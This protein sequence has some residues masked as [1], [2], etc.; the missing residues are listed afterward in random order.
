MFLLTKEWFCSDPEFH[1]H[2]DASSVKDQS[3]IIQF[4]TTHIYHVLGI[5]GT[6]ENIRSPI[7]FIQLHLSSMLF[8][9]TFR[10][11]A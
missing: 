5:G 11:T 3:L 4:T 2:F 6:P 1:F 10:Y 7:V 9:V 8:C